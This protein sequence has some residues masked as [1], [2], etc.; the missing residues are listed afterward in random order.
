MINQYEKNN[1]KPRDENPGSYSLYRVAPI[2]IV[3]RKFD[4]IS[5]AS[6]LI[7]KRYVG[8]YFF[9][10]YVNSQLAKLLDDG[11]MKCLK[12]KT[13]FHIKDN[14]EKMLNEISDALETGYQFYSKQ[15]WA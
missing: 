15:G 11:L 9:P 10:I 4:A 6:L 8:F 1:F 3:G 5:F 14:D 7:Q 2:E 12:G 13:C